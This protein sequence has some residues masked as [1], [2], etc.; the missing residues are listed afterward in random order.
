LNII[1]KVRMN[2]ADLAMEREPFESEELAALL[3]RWF[4]PVKVD[5]EER[6]DVD[7]IYMTFVQASTVGHAPKIVLGGAAYR[8]APQFARDI[9]ATEVI[10]DLREALAT[11]CA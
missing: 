4:V 5:R 2:I 9:G 8:L 7:R 11:Y 1:G 6:P 3:N 10:I